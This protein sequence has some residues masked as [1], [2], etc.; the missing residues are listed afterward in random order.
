MDSTL[1]SLIRFHS[2]NVIQTNNNKVHS[3]TP[4]KTKAER[5]W[6]LM[7]I[8]DCLE[9]RVMRIVS[10]GDV[11]FQNAFLRRKLDDLST[12]PHSYRELGRPFENESFSGP[13]EP[14]SPEKSVSS[15]DSDE[16]DDDC[17]KI[18]IRAP[19]PHIFDDCFEKNNHIS[20]NVE[21]SSALLFPFSKDSTITSIN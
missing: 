10:D 19:N 8:D 3:P 6:S 18:P 16:T 5:I 15:R 20:D 1:P 14:S 2:E 9:N 21:I 7:N 12:R 13:S 4:I 17:L 11:V